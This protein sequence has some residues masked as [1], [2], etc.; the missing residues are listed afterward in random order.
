MPLIKITAVWS[1]E[2]QVGH[3]QYGDTNDMI[4]S[5]EMAD[6]IRANTYLGD[7]WLIDNQCYFRHFIPLAIGDDLRL[8]VPK[9]YA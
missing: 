3:I 8:W 1:P 5:I 4:R 2:E 7:L 9:I 6:I